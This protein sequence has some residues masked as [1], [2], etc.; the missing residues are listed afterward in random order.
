MQVDASQPPG[1]ARTTRARSALRSPTSLLLVAGEPV[2][3]ML[4]VELVGTRLELTML[5][6]HPSQQR[7]GTGRSLVTALVGRFPAVSAWSAAPEVCEAL[8]FRR[9]GR[10]RD[11]EVELSS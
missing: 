9:T 5:F 10:A 6:V 1:Q 2:V 11:D 4:L 8:G 7:T 3:G